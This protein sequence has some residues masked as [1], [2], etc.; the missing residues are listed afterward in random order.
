MDRLGQALAL[1]ALRAPEM[2]TNHVAVLGI[3]GDLNA[4]RLVAGDEAF[5]QLFGHAAHGVDAQCRL[6]DLAHCGERHRIDEVQRNGTAARSGV[7][8]RK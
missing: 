6:E 5:E 3:V 4:Q 7:C 1:V 8:S 2:H